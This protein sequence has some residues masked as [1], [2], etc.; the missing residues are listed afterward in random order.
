[1]I[2]AV[3]SSRLPLPYKAVAKKDDPTPQPPA[4]SPDPT[5]APDPGPAKKKWTF[6][7]YSAADNNLLDAMIN[8]ITD[9]EKVGSDDY[10]NLVVQ[11]DQGGDAGA[12]RYL[13]QKNGGDSKTAVA[14]RD[15]GIAS[16]PVEQLGD[17]N[18]SAPSTLTDFIKW[19]V[20]KYP[21]ENYYLVI[22]DHGNGWQGAVEDDSQNGWATLPDLHKGID[23]AQQATGVKMSIVG[24]DA[25]LMASAEVAEELKNNADYLVVSQQTEGAYGWPY[26]QILNPQMLENL[27]KSHILKL[28]MSPQDVAVASVKQSSTIQDVLPTMSA[29]DTSKVSALTTAVDQLGGAIAKSSIDGSTLQN[30][31]DQTQDF[32]GYK[33]LVDFTQRLT[34]DPSVAS[35]ADVQSAAANVQAAVKDAVLAEEHSDDY[36][37]AHGITID[38]SSAATS[39]AYKQT[40]LGQNTQWGAAM[41]KLNGSRGPV[42][43]TPGPA[44]TA[45]QTKA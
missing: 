41:Q 28:D 7:L 3:A 45:K 42:H 21:A 1:M 29:I 24:F 22:S 23:D 17:V 19:G 33:D 9:C 11:C 26:S 34:A 4:P 6:L 36:P 8:N 30:I 37:G 15:G 13:L 35:D 32:T 14:K 12:A 44:H 10:T 40:Q 2:G 31:S 16:P 20:Q 25:C 27:Q 5:P 39:D 43:V 38:A 18:M